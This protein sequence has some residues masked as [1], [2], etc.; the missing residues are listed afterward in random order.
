MAS[1]LLIV[2]GVLDDEDHIK[3]VVKNIELGIEK[4][5][6]DMSLDEHDEMI[7]VLNNIP[8]MK[9]IPNRHAEA[10][11]V[12]SRYSGRILDT[13]VLISPTSEN[14]HY[15]IVDLFLTAT[16]RCLIAY[17]GFITEGS[18]DWVLQDGI[19]SFNNFNQILT[20]SKVIAALS[21]HNSKITISCAKLGLWADIDGESKSVLT[22]IPGSKIY[23]RVM[24][25]QVSQMNGGGD[26]QADVRKQGGDIE[27]FSSFLEEG[28]GNEIGGI[29]NTLKPPLQEGFLKI[30]NP[31]LYIFPGGNGDSAFFAVNGFN[32]LVNSGACTKPWFWKLIQ[33]VDRVDSILATH[34]GSDNLPGLNSLLLRKLQ[35][36]QVKLPMDNTSPEYQELRRCLISPDLGQLFINAP[37]KFL[38]TISKSGSLSQSPKANGKMGG[39][40]PLHDTDENVS[41][42]PVQKTVDIVKDTLRLAKALHMEMVPLV[43]KPGNPEPITLFSK[44][45]LGRLEMYVISPAENSKELAYV[46][47]KWGCNGKT[48]TPTGKTGVLNGTGGEGDSSVTNLSSICCLLVWHP[49]NPNEKIVRVLFP[50]N[51][52]QTKIF[53]GLETMK[54]LPFLKTQFATK[55]SLN[56]QKAPAKSNGTHTN[57]Q[58]ATSAT[59]AMKKPAPAPKKVT[60]PVKK[61]AVS[62]KVAEKKARPERPTT[63]RTKPAPA[64]SKASTTASKTTTVRDKVPT[65]TLKIDS[66]A[67]SSSKPSSATSVKK[68]TTSRA[69]ASTVQSKSDSKR[70]TSSTAATSRS[71]TSSKTKSQPTTQKTQEKPKKSQTL[72]P[73]KQKVDSQKSSARSTPKKL[74]KPA[75]TAAKKGIAKGSAEKP[76]KPEKLATKKVAVTPPEDLTP[77]FSNIQTG[78]AIPPTAKP[79]ELLS[80]GSEE[81][82]SSVLSGRHSP[83]GE[84]GSTVQYAESP[85]V[86]QNGEEKEKAE[87]GNENVII[88]P[89]TQEQEDTGF[90]IMNKPEISEESDFISDNGSLAGAHAT[91][92]TITDENLLQANNDDLISSDKSTTPEDPVV[93]HEKAIAFVDPGEGA[94]ASHKP[95]IRTPTPFHSL[96]ESSGETNENSPISESEGTAGGEVDIKKDSALEEEVDHQDE[97]VI[98]WSDGNLQIEEDDSPLDTADEKEDSNEKESPEGQDDIA[99][100]ETAIPATTE[101]VNAL[102]PAKDVGS[103]VHSS[104]NSSLEGS[105]ELYHTGRSPPPPSDRQ[106]TIAE[107]ISDFKDDGNFQT[108]DFEDQSA[109]LD[110]QPQQTDLLEDPTMSM[111]APDLRFSMSTTSTGS[112]FARMDPPFSSSDAG[113]AVADEPAPVTQQQ[114][115][116]APG[117]SPK[118]M[119]TSPR[120]EDDISSLCG[121]GADVSTDATIPNSNLLISSSAQQ[122]FVEPES[123]QSRFAEDDDNCVEKIDI[124]DFPAQSNIEKDEGDLSEENQITEEADNQEDEEMIADAPNKEVIGGAHEEETDPKTFDENQLEASGLIRRPD[125][126]FVYDEDRQ[127]Q[128]QEEIGYLHS[129]QNEDKADWTGEGVEGYDIQ[130]TG[131]NDEMK[132]A[133][134]V[135]PGTDVDFKEDVQAH[136]KDIDNQD[137]A[138]EVA[139]VQESQGDRP[140]MLSAEADGSLAS[141]AQD[142]GEQYYDEYSEETSLT[143]TGETPDVEQSPV[144]FK[145]DGPNIQDY[146]KVE[147]DVISKS[148]LSLSSPEENFPLHGG[149]SPDQDLF[150]LNGNVEIQ[151]KDT[152]E[153]ED[154]DLLMGTGQ[155]QDE[156]QV[157]PIPRYHPAYI[158]PIAPLADPEEIQSDQPAELGSPLDANAKPFV[159]KS[160]VPIDQSPT[161]A[162]EAQFGHADDFGTAEGFN[163]A[164]PTLSAGMANN[165]PFLVDMM[166]SNQPDPFSAEVPCLPPVRGPDPCAAQDNKNTKVHPRKANPGTQ[167]KK[168]A[169]GFSPIHV[170]LTYVPNHANKN[171]V[172]IDFFKK[173]RSK[174]YVVSGNDQ[175]KD[176]PSTEVLN[177]LLEGKKSWLND[178]ASHSTDSDDINVTVI[179]THDTTAVREWYKQNFKEL[180]SCNIH[181]VASGSKVLVQVESIEACKIEF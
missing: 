136:L 157:T 150:G 147:G 163:A 143:E 156:Q 43:R 44:V 64:A 135:Q 129:N 158:D 169:S 176:E 115:E 98:Q 119:M 159:P 178:G 72:T 22:P 27:E 60:P 32:M 105:Y 47:E 3:Q 65:K 112:Q 160:S 18:G 73:S 81:P 123:N 39:A 21:E 66:T 141:S 173:I 92:K 80:T 14:L 53:E 19:F 37:A 35:E 88:H 117:I 82:T 28:I 168:P 164:S 85:T 75:P 152:E 46:N 2:I 67:A 134:A 69:G 31:C 40:S 162:S 108:K 111:E 149:T 93:E 109:C 52:S 6:S 86:Q 181:M 131:G 96:Q 29:F 94:D 42:H 144:D 7:H 102:D 130:E 16:P 87:I 170:D 78:D 24:D 77:E 114:L 97:A 177:H 132:V 12:I 89:P 118:L 155:D 166:Q 68:G 9:S 153:K 148:D 51:A 26:H 100:S 172:G 84:D 126:I 104:F 121:V 139:T 11:T 38:E 125:E 15:E 33:H 83:E 116:P 36:R 154:Q 179:P 175:T 20:D 30:R 145:Y 1:K 5:M 95:V 151:T 63:T 10:G 41:S 8:S 113:P 137:R 133:D 103:E 50:G 146:E 76:Q 55:N 99:Q 34:L 180:E 4:W 49:Y 127:E 101:N 45:G 106:E 56:K 23:L 57:T 138:E 120:T 107:T 124:E 91:A 161:C 128:R 54:N 48:T 122:I 165:N 25:L 140:N 167:A 61:E 62:N 59:S 17:S 79:A 174:Y 71:A 142:Q 74:S 110:T 13:T 58:R 171:S 70:P 90:V